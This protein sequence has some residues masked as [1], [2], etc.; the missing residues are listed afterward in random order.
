MQKLIL[1]ENKGHNHDSSA[2]IKKDK[3]ITERKRIY[4]TLVKA[5][6]QP[7]EESFVG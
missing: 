6:H 1:K 5:D 2:Y 3:L 4:L 7:L